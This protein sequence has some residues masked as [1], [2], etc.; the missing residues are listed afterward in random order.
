MGII[1]FSYFKEIGK[2]D[3]IITL[4]YMYVLAI[5]GSFMLRDGIMEID[6]IKKK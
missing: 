6:R 5:L 4:S 1:T 3:L 2:I